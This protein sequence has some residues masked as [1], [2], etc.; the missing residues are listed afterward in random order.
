MLDDP[1]GMDGGSVEDGEVRRVMDN[2]KGAVQYSYA[3]FHFMLLL[4][5]LY[6]MMTLT[7][8]YR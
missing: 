8:W 7:N 1:V 4:A 6:I 3:F 5:S 2:E